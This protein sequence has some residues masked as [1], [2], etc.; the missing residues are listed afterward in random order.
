MNIYHHMSSVIVCGVISRHITSNGTRMVEKYPFR[1]RRITNSIPAIP[2][3]DPRETQGNYAWVS[4]QKR[5]S[6][7]VSITII[8][9][10]LMIGVG[11]LA[12]LT[13]VGS[14]SSPAQARVVGPGCPTRSKT[15]IKSI[16][17]S[18]SVCSSRV[19]IANT[20]DAVLSTLHIRSVNVRQFG[21]TDATYLLLGGKLAVFTCLTRQCRQL[22]LVARSNGSSGPIATLEDS[23]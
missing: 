19:G 5:P 4:L 15:G 16:G 21:P 14:L 20:G 10:T 13:G 3:P 1:P 17:D 11:G 7:S 22:F 23:S 8:H 6:P 18:T 2:R 12:M 9:T